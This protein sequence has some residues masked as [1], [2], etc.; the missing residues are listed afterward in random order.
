MK[1]PIIRV[2]DYLTDTTYSG[3]IKDI[4]FEFKETGIYGLLGA[5][6][7]GKSTLMNIIAGF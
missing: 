7:A 6:G 5:N 3:R 2:K 4:N 1:E